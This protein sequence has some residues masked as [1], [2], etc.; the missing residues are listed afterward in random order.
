MGVLRWDERKHCSRAKEHALFDSGFNDLFRCLV[1][2]FPGFFV[3]V[4]SGVPYTVGHL[5]CGAAGA[6]PPPWAFLGSF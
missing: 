5:L 6:M 2:S 4:H 3:G 1:P